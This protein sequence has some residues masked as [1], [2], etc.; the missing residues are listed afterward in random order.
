MNH[1]YAKG[2]EERIECQSGEKGRE[3]EGRESKTDL[4][5]TRRV[6]LVRARLAS[7]VGEGSIR[8]G[9]DRVADRTV[10]HSG[11]VERDVALEE[12]EGVQDQ[13]V[14]R[15]ERESARSSQR[16]LEQADGGRR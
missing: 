12:S 10:C 11:E 14:L 3:Q 5:K 7:S 8:N 16:E 1:C 6:E 9:D 4:V 2:I 15:G 13:T